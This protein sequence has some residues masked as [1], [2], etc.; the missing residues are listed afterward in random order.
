MVTDTNEETP[1]ARF[2]GVPSTGASVPMEPGCTTTSGR[3]K[4][5]P[6]QKLP[7]SCTTGIFVALPHLCIISC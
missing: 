4:C 2:R 6:T 3:Q 5:L 7:R 1:W